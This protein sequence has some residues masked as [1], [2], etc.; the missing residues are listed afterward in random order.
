[1]LSE[2][3]GD[4]VAEARKRAASWLWGKE[5]GAQV[6]AL[7]KPLIDT[8][9]EM[10]AKAAKPAEAKELTQEERELLLAGVVSGSREEGELLGLQ[11][12]EQRRLVEEEKARRLVPRARIAIE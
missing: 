10:R 5:V 12:E 4:P 1:M 2:L 8:L 7:N 9:I 3:L 6:G 11:L